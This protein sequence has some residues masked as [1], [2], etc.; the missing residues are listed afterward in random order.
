MTSRSLLAAVIPG[1][2]LSACIP[3]PPP[4]PLPKHPELPFSETRKVSRAAA[5][6]GKVTEMDLS[7]FFEFQQSGQALIYD[8]RPTFV[9]QFGTIPGAIG[10]PKSEFSAKIATREAEIRSARQHGQPVVL[11]CTDAE[12]PDARTVAD[13]LAARGHDVSVLQ[14]GYSSWKESGLAE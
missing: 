4:P 11:Y 6:P 2:L 1:L 12:C 8:V 7:T 10:W 5:H 13:K 9:Q 14:G 3:P